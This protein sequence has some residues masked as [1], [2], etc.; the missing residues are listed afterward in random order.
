MKKKKKTVKLL[1]HHN[2]YLRRLFNPSAPGN[3]A[4]NLYKMRYWSLWAAQC[5]FPDTILLSENDSW[6]MGVLTIKEIMPE[7]PTTKYIL[8]SWTGKIA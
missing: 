6:D 5:F 1:M 8:I 4:Q 7:Q 3:F 2:N